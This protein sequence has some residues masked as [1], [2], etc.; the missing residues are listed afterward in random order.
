MNP[1]VKIRA[2]QAAGRGSLPRIE[3]PKASWFYL[4][5]DG[6]ANPYVTACGPPSF[7][8][9]TILEDFCLGHTRGG[10]RVILGSVDIVTG[11]GGSLDLS[12]RSSRLQMLQKLHVTSEDFSVPVEDGV[13]FFNDVT[14]VNL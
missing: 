14:F 2:F 9:L 6:S 8:N 12:F 13:R 10:V 4:I 7:I 5:S 11:R 1:K 3:G